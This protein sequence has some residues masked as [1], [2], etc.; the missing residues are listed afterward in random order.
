[1]ESMRG[2]FV[3]QG[4]FTSTTPYELNE[5]YCGFACMNVLY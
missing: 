5:N 3:Y 1:M 4:F 2:C